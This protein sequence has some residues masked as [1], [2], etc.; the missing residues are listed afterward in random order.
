L[1]VKLD[2]TRAITKVLHSG[3]VDHMQWK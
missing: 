2:L 1:L 3:G